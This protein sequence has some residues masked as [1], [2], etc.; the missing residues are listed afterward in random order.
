MTG[1]FHI[2][3]IDSELP[4]VVPNVP[5]SNQEL[6]K[7]KLPNMLSAREKEW[8]GREYNSKAPGLRSIHQS[9]IDS[10]KVRLGAVSVPP[11]PSLLLPSSSQRLVKLHER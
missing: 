7:Q 6:R 3:A 5:K 11:Q 8:S 4:S 1:R 10:T 9:L 2:V